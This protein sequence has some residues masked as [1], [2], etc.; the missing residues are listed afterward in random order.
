MHQAEQD[1]YASSCI[2]QCSSDESSE[3][4]VVV[5]LRATRSGIRRRAEG[6]SFRGSNGKG[7]TYRLLQSFEERCLYNSM[8]VESEQISPGCLQPAACNRPSSMLA[9]TA[10]N[11]QDC[12][13]PWPEFRHT[14]T[15][16]NSPSKYC[17]FWVLT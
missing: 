3:E 13:S 10:E 6:R 4:Q 15:H 9:K 7:K 16:L 14:R 12:R 8:T 11:R 1:A 17:S 2:Q 5:T